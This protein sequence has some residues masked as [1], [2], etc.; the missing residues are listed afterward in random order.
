VAV[1]KDTERFCLLRNLLAKEPP[2][3][4]LRGEKISVLPEGGPL[5]SGK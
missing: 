3:G 5:A 2:S 4:I 1:Q